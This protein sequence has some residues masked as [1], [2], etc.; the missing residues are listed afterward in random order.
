MQTDAAAR[1]R[2]RA[3]LLLARVSN[4]PTVWTNVLAGMCA[5][6]GT[7]ELALWVRVTAAISCFY[8]AGML[9]NDALDARFDK[10]ARPTRPIPAGDVAR[11][12]VV[13]VAGALFVLGELLLFPRLQA[14]I[15][16]LAL[17]AAIVFYDAR[18]KGSALAPFVMGACRGL[19]YVVAA[20]ARGSLNVA[21][22]IGAV[23]MTGYVV[24]LTFFAQRATAG[25][26]WLV[27]VLI[28]GISIVDAVFILAMTGSAQLASLGATGFLLT[29]FLQRFV[30]GD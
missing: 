21:A 9:L 13:V 26:R 15:L 6:P 28:A 5:I 12:E 2:W 1:P 8:G 22:G 29:L 10:D 17:I 24:V 27:P 25:Q 3:Y 4:L 20:A 14:L 18:H 23:V 30:P 16:G 11:R 19:V 7:V